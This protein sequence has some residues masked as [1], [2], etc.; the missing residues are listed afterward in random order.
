MR[1]VIGKIG[2]FVCAIVV[3]LVFTGCALF[4]QNLDYDYGRVVAA[5]KL[6]NDVIIKI[7][8]KELYDAYTSYGYQYV[9]N[10]GYS[11]EEAYQ[12]II[13]SLI[14]REVLIK[15][16][17]EKFG[18]GDG[19]GVYGFL[20]NYEADTARKNAF[21]ALNKGLQTYIDEFNGVESATDDTT[22]ED[23]SVKYTPYDKTILYDENKGTFSQNLDSYKEV[24]DIGI[25]PKIWTPEVP[26]GTD[27]KTFTRALARV[28]RN[29]ESREKGFYDL[30]NSGNHNDKDHKGEAW[31]WFV[32]STNTIVKNN[33]NS[34]EQEVLNREIL[35]I[36]K[37]NEKTT[38]T[39]RMETLFTLG[40][41]GV[42][43]FNIYMNRGNV[44]KGADGVEIDGFETFKNA[45][46]N[47]GVATNAA[48]S[49]IT[50]YKYL[51]MQGIVDY[52][53]T[54]PE[55]MEGTL[56]ATGEGNGLS[57][58]YYVP[59]SVADN[60]FTVSHILVSFTD[61]QKTRYTEISTLADTD[62]SFD[63]ENEMLKLYAETEY[64]GENVYEI[65]NNIKSVVDSAET[66]QEKYDTFR[67][68][69]YKYNAENNELINPT[70]EYVMSVNTDKNQMIAEFTNASIELKTGKDQNGDGIIHGGSK[71]GTK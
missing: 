17:V 19:A 40:L 55:D 70:F 37:S 31:G 48:S 27:T 9:Q 10:Y 65:Y 58:V 45:V 18:S 53:T 29:L 24:T 21:D 67:D 34:D 11:L 30:I 41:D 62:S 26:A 59:K 44:V 51:V 3:A 6:S 28:I 38:L 4:E 23:T 32:N 1:K 46:N 66:T 5:V 36:I 2:A 8:K 39:S 71:A 64:Q 49:A 15:I 63:K 12:A 22:E 54:P 14:E 16:S 52:N 50:A 68:L 13:D 60:L 61:E 35:R 43:G 20:T 25:V 47:S 56:L 42:D 69:I 7:T 57:G 33:L